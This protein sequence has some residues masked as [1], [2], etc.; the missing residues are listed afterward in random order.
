MQLFYQR[1][2]SPDISHTEAITTYNKTIPTFMI[3]SAQKLPI[4]QKDAKEE[5]PIPSTMQQLLLNAA[6]VCR[7]MAM[8]TKV[9]A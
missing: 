5:M 1:K 3:S 6:E 8:Q 2:Y 4:K 9:R 7:S